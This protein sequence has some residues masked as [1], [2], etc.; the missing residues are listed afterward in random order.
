MSF[1][2]APGKIPR[3]S[4]QSSNPPLVGPRSAP[5]PARELTRAGKAG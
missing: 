4:V 3:G 1:P 5:R 2:Y